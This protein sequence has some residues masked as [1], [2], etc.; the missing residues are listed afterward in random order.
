MVAV[1]GTASRMML[2][3]DYMDGRERHV[4]HDMS[5]L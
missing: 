4:A 5:M 1:G 2:G 3:R